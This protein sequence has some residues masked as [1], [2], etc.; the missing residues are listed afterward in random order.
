[1][2][3]SYTSDEYVETYGYP[4]YFFY[5][6][7]VGSTA[8]EERYYTTE[9]FR[10]DYRENNKVTIRFVS[11]WVD[12]RRIAYYVQKYRN[13][14]LVN[15]KTMVSVSGVGIGPLDNFEILAAN[16]YVTLLDGLTVVYSPPRKKE[17]TNWIKI[18][19]P[20]LTLLAVV[21]KAIKPTITEEL[22]GAYTF[23]FEYVIDDEKSQ[24]MQVGNIVEV[25]N[26]YF[27]IC[28]RRESKC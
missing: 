10:V 26:N 16:Y 17:P 27:R 24:Y 5:R 6:Y 22:N 11:E 13:G 19:N 12:G 15:E 23:D 8:Y 21:A 7:S 1:M 28:C 25:E 18:Y 20:N 3:Y 9:K 2:L 4:Y 14:I